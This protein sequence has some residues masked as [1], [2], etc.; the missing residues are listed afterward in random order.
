MN[1]YRS[2]KSPRHLMQAIFLLIVILAIT[3]FA[4]KAGVGWLLATPTS[5]SSNTVMPTL[6]MTMINTLPPTYTPTPTYTSTPMPTSVPATVTPAFVSLPS[7]NALVSVMLENP[8]VLMDDYLK[9]TVN[10]IINLGN[11]VVGRSGSGTLSIKPEFSD[12]HYFLVMTVLVEKIT[13]QDW[14]FG[15]HCF[16]SS[17]ISQ[18]GWAGEGC[19]SMK[20]SSDGILEC[21]GAGYS[22]PLEDPSDVFWQQGMFLPVDNEDTVEIYLTFVVPNDL[23]QF[24]I[25]LE[26]VLAN[27]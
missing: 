25:S 16:D 19:L 20:D 3:Q 2:I 24:I 22:D 14:G 12:T 9:I 4:C 26:A 17:T 10:D 5:T 18:I 8:V 23:E 27:P 6:T 21:A 13:D 1:I 11:Q 7:S 15:T